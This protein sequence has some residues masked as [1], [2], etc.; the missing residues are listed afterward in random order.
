MSARV[1]SIEWVLLH[2]NFVRMCSL[3]AFMCT[4]TFCSPMRALICA[5]MCLLARVFFDAYARGLCFHVRVCSQMCGLI[6]I[7]VI[8]VHMFVDSYVCL[9]CMLPY[10]CSRMC[11]LSLSIYISLSLSLYECSHIR[12]ACVS[13]HMCAPQLCALTCSQR[14]VLSVYVLT[15][16]FSCAPHAHVCC[17]Y[18]FIHLVCSHVHSL[19]QVLSTKQGLPTFVRVDARD[20]ATR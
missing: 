11:A 13:S 7:Y 3:W 2:E 14:H 15:C 18:V 17:M 6:Y 20:S 16:A 9:T 8:C 10:T 12:H 19:L 1:C 4:R 5:P